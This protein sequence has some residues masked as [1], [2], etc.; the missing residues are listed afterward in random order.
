[1][2]A[3]LLHNHDVPALAVKFTVPPAQNVVAPPAVIVAVGNAFTVTVVNADVAE[4]PLA[5]L[6][7]TLNDPLLVTAIV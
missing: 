4:Q 2:V 6:T 1:M 3:P 7:V 5:L